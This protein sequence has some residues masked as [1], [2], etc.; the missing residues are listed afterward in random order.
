M[1]FALDS[2]KLMLVFN[3]YERKY[4]E[5]KRKYA[6]ATFAKW[7]CGS[8]QMGGEISERLIQIVPK[9]LTFEQKYELIEKLWSRLRQ[10]ITLNVTISPHGGLNEAIQAVMG[11][12]DALGEQAIPVA[13]VERL[14]WLAQDDAAVA[15]SLIAQIAKREGEVA[16]ERLEE[17]LRQLLALA[18][19]HQDIVVTATR[20]VALPG[21]TAH[22]HVSQLTSTTARKVTMS[23]NQNGMNENNPVP[24]PR[25]N[26]DQ[27]RRE[28]APIQ[29]PRDLLSEA[30]RRIAPKKQNQI[31]EKVAEEVARIEVKRAE[32]HV[33][34]EMAASKVEQAAQAATRFDNA[35]T[36]FEV[37][38]EHHSEHGSVHFTVR[39][40]RLPTLAQRAGC[41]VA[42]ACYGDYSHPA[43]IVL[44]RFRDE[45]LRESAA[46]RAFTAWYYRISPR[47]AKFIEKRPAFRLAGRLLLWPIV[48]VAQGVVW[49]R[50]IFGKRVTR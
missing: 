42:T 39:N 24:L 25:G 38:A 33:D 10:T 11:A 46:G 34:A 6:E 5:G 7:R 44:R 2:F 36:E 16:V 14:E 49:L 32:G 29:H 17:Q 20:S 43:V 12:I 27:T 41:F 28:I 15:Q 3:E 37:K 31:V 35:G 30:L 4:G 47:I 23:E 8:V 48:V 26:D 1:F 50:R 22:I 40:K 21:I 45:C 9:W 18:S 13:V 19:E